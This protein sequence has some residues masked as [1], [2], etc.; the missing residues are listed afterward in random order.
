[1]ANQVLYIS[2]IRQYAFGV[3]MLTTINHYKD[4]DASNVRSDE[5]N[6][7][8]CTVVLPALND[9]QGDFVVNDS[10]YTYHAGGSGNAYL[11]YPGGIGGRV[12]TPQDIEPLFLTATV[13]WTVSETEQFG[14]R[15]TEVRSSYT[16]IS[17]ILDEDVINGQLST[18]MQTLLSSTFADAW[19]APVVVGPDTF[20]TVA[21]VN[22]T[23]TASGWKVAELDSYMYARLG[24]QRTRRT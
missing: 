13:R 14:P 11:R 20:N 2:R 7:H 1:M 9:L 22:K 15:V 4:A 17:G 18:D 5:I 23:E 19:L 16:R 12:T 8:V 24:T 6:E 21:H 10:V 3:T